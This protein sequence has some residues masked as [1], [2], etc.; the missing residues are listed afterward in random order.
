MLWPDCKTSKNLG[1]V[2]FWTNSK[3]RKIKFKKKGIYL[4]APNFLQIF[5]VKIIAISTSDEEYLRTPELQLGFN[6]NL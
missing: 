5:P 2:G 3:I 1:I 6:F 4:C